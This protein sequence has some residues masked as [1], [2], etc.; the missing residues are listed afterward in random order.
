MFPKMIGDYSE[1][2][3]KRVL[4]SRGILRTDKDGKNIKARIGSVSKRFI[5]LD[6]AILSGKTE[7]EE[8]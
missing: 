6:G 5:V 1:R 7:W 3:A 2:D 4:K 8:G